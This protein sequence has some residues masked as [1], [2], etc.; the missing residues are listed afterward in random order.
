MVIQQNHPSLRQE[1]PI[2]RMTFQCIKSNLLWPSS[3]QLLYEIASQAVVAC[4]HSHQPLE[5]LSSSSPHHDRLLYKSILEERPYLSHSRF[6]VRVPCQENLAGSYQN[7][8]KCSSRSTKLIHGYHNAQSY[9]SVEGVHGEARR[10]DCLS[11]RFSIS[12]NILNFDSYLLASARRREQACLLPVPVFAELVLPLSLL[13]LCL[14]KWS[15]SRCS[16]S[17]ER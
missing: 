17:A 6:S 13:S 3:G 4:P 14:C 2:K 11:G 10:G 16:V 12:F 1:S 15:H 5:S 7:T 9:L 8:Y